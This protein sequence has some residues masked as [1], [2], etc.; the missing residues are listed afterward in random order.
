MKNRAS[1]AICA[2]ALLTTPAL[3]GDAMEKCVADTT[4]Y[5]ADDPQAGCECFMEAVSEETADAYALISD[6]ETE[7]TDE[8][9]A[10]GAACFPE[11]Q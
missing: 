11:I 9:K 8:M 10:A 4:A 6:W 7:A 5:G 1:L 3:A 2:A